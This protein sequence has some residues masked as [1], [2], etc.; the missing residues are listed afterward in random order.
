MTKRDQKDSAG[1][2]GIRWVP[3]GHRRSDARQRA[4]PLL[5]GLCL[6]TLAGSGCTNQEVYDSTE[7]W[8]ITQCDRYAPRDREEC[9]QQARM[10]YSEYKTNRHEPV[11]SPTPEPTP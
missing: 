5:S 3:R 1:L 9:L 8:R 6:I 11:P 10:P 7:A 4:L 2:D